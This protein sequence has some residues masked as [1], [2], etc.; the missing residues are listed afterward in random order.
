MALQFLRAKLSILPSLFQP[1][2][3]AIFSTFPWWQRWRLL[4]LQPINLLTA[5]ITSPTW[6]FNNRYTVLY[7]STRSGQ[8]RCLVYLPR[9]QDPKTRKILRPIHLDIHGGAFIGGLPEHD[10]RWCS[11]LSDSTGAVVVSCSYRL[12]PRHTFPAAHDDVDDIVTYLLSNAEAQFGADPN[13]FTTSGSSV[14]GNLALSTAID[15]QRSQPS[16]ESQTQKKSGVGVKAF[17][18]FYTPVDFRLKPEQKPKPPSFPTS[19]PLAFLLPMYDAYAGPSRQAN[20]TNPRLNPIIA[21]KEFL[22]QNILLIVP[23]IDILVHEQLS[24]VERIRE[25]LEREGGSESR[26][27]AKVIENAFHGWIELPKAVLEKERIDAF[28]AGV[29][30]I[31]EVHSRCGFDVGAI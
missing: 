10:T 5:L 9:N 31:K 29:L 30:F 16:M 24:L 8:K 19:D 15:L 28:E 12:A 11:Y 3:D 14:G 4:T 23:G 25:E 27:E 18:G 20:L 6:L 21:E 26:V 17:V 13:L 22:P 2:Y 7:I 1:A